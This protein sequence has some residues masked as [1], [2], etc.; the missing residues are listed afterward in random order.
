MIKNR[1]KTEVKYGN[2]GFFFDRCE[3]ED[4]D[5]LVILLPLKKKTRKTMY[6]K[7]D[8]ATCY[9][10]TRTRKAGPCLHINIAE[11]IY[12]NPDMLNQIFIYGKNQREYLIESYEKINRIILLCEKNPDHLKNKLNNSVVIQIIKVI[13]R[14]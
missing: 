2:Q 6:S 12:V 5:F 9:C 10:I 13:A 7:F 11:Y 4:E 1:R 14:K 3:E 8:P